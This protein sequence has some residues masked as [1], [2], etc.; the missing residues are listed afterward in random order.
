MTVDSSTAYTLASNPV[1]NATF[2]YAAFVDTLGQVH[3]TQQDTAGIGGPLIDHIFNAA[4]DPVAAAVIGSPIANMTEG[5][6][7]TLLLTDD[8]RLTLFVNMGGG[9]AGTFRTIRTTAPND[10]T[11]WGN[12]VGQWATTLPVNRVFSPITWN[13]PNGRGMV[14]LCG[15]GNGLNATFGN[16]DGQ[17]WQTL[18][19]GSF[20]PFTT[21][22]ILP[23]FRGVAVPGAPVGSAWSPSVLRPVIEDLGGGQFNEHWFWS[24][25]PKNQTFSVL[26]SYAV[27]RSATNSWH[28]IDNTPVNPVFDPIS[29]P[30]LQTGW[31]DEEGAGFQFA[32]GGSFTLTPAGNPV[33]LI[34]WRPTY[35]IAWDGTKWGRLRFPLVGPATAIT[36]AGVDVL[37]RMILVYLHRAIWYLFAGSTVADPVVRAYA[38]SPGIGLFPP[39]ATIRAVPLGAAVPAGAV[40]EVTYDHD[41]LDRDGVIQVQTP[42]GIRDSVFV[43]VGPPDRIRRDF[44]WDFGIWSESVWGA[45]TPAAS[46][47]VPGAPTGASAIAGNA[48]ATVSW[49]FPASDGGSAIT[50][51]RITPYIGVT[52]Q[53]S[54]NVG[55]VASTTVS[56]TNGT[57]YTFKVAAINAIGTGA[58]SAASNAVTPPSATVPGAPTGASAVA[59]NAQATVSWTAP[60]SNGGSAITG[61]RVTPYIGVTAQTAVN[62]GNV[63]STTITGLTNGTTYTFKVAATNAIGTG[64][65]SAASNAVT[66]PPPPPGPGLLWTGDAD[67][68]T[69]RGNQTDC[70]GGDARDGGTLTISPDPLGIYG[71]VYRA[72]VVGDSQRAEWEGVFNNCDGVTKLNLWGT[73]APGTSDLYIGWRSQFTGNFALTGATNDGNV[74]QWKGD[75][76]SCGGPSVGMTLNANRLSL[77]TLDGNTP[78]DGVSGLWMDPTLFSGRMNQWIDFV[79]RVNFSQGVDGFIEF[80][81]N[82]VRQTMANGTQRFTGPTVCPGASKVY[83]KWGVYSLAAGA[84]A[85]HLLETPRIG[86]T[87]GSVAP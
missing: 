15:Q 81:V 83:P 51:Y 22:P 72:H 33:A 50:G 37:S 67:T 53:T 78:L 35:M 31:D 80:W 64:A 28:A 5:T 16:A 69:D 76:T 60:A 36:I 79:M 20:G 38:V 12:A 73:G 39:P 86:T 14:Y 1:S 23:Y 49:T 2:R 18:P 77:R 61:Y 44:T 68:D 71:D 4:Q 29:Q 74:V 8:G 55:N 48:Q 9:T 17:V 46:A 82:G 70:L 75:D 84:D 43:Q 7:P 58:L 6:Y 57:Q 27:Y 25:R 41:A 3:V 13:R 47:T 56:L 26:P 19:N 65:Q 54:V 52:A 10:I 62:V 45:V 11:A 63:A 30:T 59:G 24:W 40:W 34:G 21:D 87:Y 66:P 85:V 32:D 42:L